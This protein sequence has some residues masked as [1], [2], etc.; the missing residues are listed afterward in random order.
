MKEFFCSKEEICSFA[1]DVVTLQA[2]GGEGLSAAPVEW[3]CSDPS[4]VRIRSFAGEEGGFADK[5]LLTLLKE[6][7][8]QVTASLDGQEATCQVKVRS[9]KHAGPEEKMNYYRGDMHAHTGYSDGVGTPE[10]ALARV[11]EEKFLD[12]YTIS[13]HGIAYTPEKCFTNVLAAEQATDEQFVTLPA[14]EADLY[15]ELR[16]DYGFWVNQG[17]EL[18]T[19]Q[20]E[21]WARTTDWDS[22]FERVGEHS[23]L[24]LGMPHPSDVGGAESTMWNGYNLPYLREPR[25]K[26]YLRFVE[27][28]N[29]PT[30]EAYN[31]LHERIFSQALDFGYHVC[32][33]AGSDT[34]SYNW[35]EGAMWSRT[36]IMAPELSKEAIIDAMLSGRVYV[37]ESG[38]VKLK[39]QVN[40][41]HPGGTVK[42]CDFYLCDFSFDVFRPANENER[43]VKAELFSDYG[44]VVDSVELNRSRI[45]GNYTLISRDVNARYFYL[46]LTD[47]AGDRTW[48]APIWTDNAPDEPLTLPKGKKIPREE[49]VVLS[50]PGKNPEK[51]FNGNPNDGWLSDEMPAEI[52]IDLGKVRRICGLG[53]YHHFVEIKNCTHVAQLLGKFK[54]EVSVDG[55]NYEEAVRRNMRSYGSEQVTP[56]SPK[57]ARYLRLTILTSVG[58]E[59]GTPMYRDIPA[60]IGE[61]SVYESEE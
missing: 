12:F 24:M 44:E 39:F 21:K 4:V 10:M 60:A 47:A 6:G 18:L 43:I 52:L 19:F 26:K 40:G 56:F 25:A 17:G 58:M 51:L 53:Y 8:A 20:G 36:V 15:F 45:R 7:S 14:Q 3:S 59:R 22:Y 2:C 46:R 50:A 29:S 27:I 30:F 34:H 16:D 31:L 13:D 5:V 33:S 55:V 41:V 23:A 57:E 35:G 28:L 54:L 1:G 48:S 9:L 42:A 38:N 37:T 61:L 49:C 32:P 11:K